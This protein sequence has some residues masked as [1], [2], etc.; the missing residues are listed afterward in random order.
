M[1]GVSLK[2][3]LKPYRLSDDL[4]AFIH[5]TTFSCL[6]FHW[7]DM[8][9]LPL[10]ES[11]KPGEKLS[12][13]ELRNFN[14]DNKELGEHVAIYYHACYQGGLTGR[15]VD[16]GGKAKMIYAKAG[17]PGWKL[18]DAPR[19][20]KVLV[21]SLCKLMKRHYKT[22]NFRKLDKHYARA[23]VGTLSTIGE[24]SSSDDDDTNEEATSADPF[25]KKPNPG[26]DLNTH[27]RIMSIFEG[28]RNDLRRIQAEGLGLN[29]K[30]PDQF[31]GLREWYDDPPR[32]PSGSR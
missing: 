29:D 8:S 23:R 12:D 14:N 30:S 22:I 26:K 27:S 32:D 2:Y 11:Y 31:L 25:T 3:P 19:P 6:R 17:Q 18:T 20:L 10:Q 16:S 1:S 7:H 5:V 9:H 13:A 4:E 28:A 24:D 15:G 21:K